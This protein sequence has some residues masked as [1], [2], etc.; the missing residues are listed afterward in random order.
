MPRKRS[1]A[2]YIESWYI[3]KAGKLMKFCAAHD[4]RIILEGSKECMKVC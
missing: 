1:Q 4:R 2:V 3:H